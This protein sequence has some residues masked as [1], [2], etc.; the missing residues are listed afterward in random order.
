MACLALSCLSLSG[1]GSYFWFRMDL[2]TEQEL[3]WL[4][5]LPDLLAARLGYNASAVLDQ[6]N[7]LLASLG[8]ALLYLANALCM[9]GCNPLQSALAR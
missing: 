6:I 3:T 7:S 8:L 4:A 2:W 5:L 9:C 1:F